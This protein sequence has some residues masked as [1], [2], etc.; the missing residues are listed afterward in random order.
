MRPKKDDV[1]W[2]NNLASN[3]KEKKYIST[4]LL[5]SKPIQDD[6]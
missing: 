2:V 4:L 1:M 5:I 6:D 3:L